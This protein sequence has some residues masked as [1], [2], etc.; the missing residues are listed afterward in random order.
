MST[1][2]DDMLRR[3]NTAG[4][5]TA[6]QPMGCLY[7]AAGSA[8]TVTTVRG[9]DVAPS[10][11]GTWGHWH[12]K[13]L[14]RRRKGC[15]HT[16]QLTSASAAVAAVAIT[17]KN[18]TPGPASAENQ[19]QRGSGEPQVGQGEAQRLVEGVSGVAVPSHGAEGG[20]GGAS[21]EPAS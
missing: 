1:V 21:P 6:S 20:A 12:A 9:G 7:S 5:S 2:T 4:S 15:C 17:K 18:T 14:S 3:R 10:G 8:R 13:Q 16:C 11:V 19:L